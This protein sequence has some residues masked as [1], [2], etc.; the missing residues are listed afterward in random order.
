M[1]MAVSPKPRPK[2]TRAPAL[3][4]CISWNFANPVAEGIT[5]T[6]PPESP[7]GLS[8]MS[9]DERIRRKRQSTK[10]CL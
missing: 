7:H 4:P 5:T 9:K 1:H 10:R 8:C 2:R 3:N 6:P